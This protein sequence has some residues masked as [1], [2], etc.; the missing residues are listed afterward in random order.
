MRE[1]DIERQ[2]KKRAEEL[3]GCVWKMQFP[4]RRGAPDRLVKIPGRRTVF[5][6]LKAPNGRLSK[7]QEIEHRRMR[8][9]G[10]RVRVVWSLGDIEGALR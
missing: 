6:E 3:G 2:L 10:L 9:V 1:R 4:G 7:L 8:K 5:V